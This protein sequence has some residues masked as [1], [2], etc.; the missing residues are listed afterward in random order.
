MI[1]WVLLSIVEPSDFIFESPDTNFPLIFLA[2][3]AFAIVYLFWLSLSVV[4]TLS[5]SIKDCG[6]PAWALLLFSWE[7]ILV[8]IRLAGFLRF[9]D[10]RPIYFCEAAYPKIEYV[11]FEFCGEYSGF[12]GLLL[13]SGKRFESLKAGFVLY[14]CCL[15]EKEIAGVDCFLFNL[16]SLKLNLL[17]SVT[18]LFDVV[19]DPCDGVI[20]PFIIPL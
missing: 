8:G 13:E 6:D 19:K 12:G 16:S 3:L 9:I 10:L 15:E 11:F 14:F 4:S 5:F 18:R 2:S 20:F 17:P 7:G 1:P